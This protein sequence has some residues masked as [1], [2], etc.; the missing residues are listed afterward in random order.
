MPL[1]RTEF[2][3]AYETMRLIR[4]FEEALLRLYGEAKVPGFAHLSVWQEAIP[5]G[6]AL[7]LRRDDVIFSTHRGHGDLIA[8]GVALEGLFAE[9]LARQGG[10]SRA[11]GGSV[12]VADISARAGA[13]GSSAPTC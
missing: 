4:E 6:V 10:L 7:N 9:L 11:K 8:K 3:G 5:T 1:A 12:H 13:T 2:L